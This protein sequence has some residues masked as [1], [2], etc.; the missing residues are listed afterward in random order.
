MTSFRLSARCVRPRD[1]LKVIQRVEARG[2]VDTA[3]R[4]RQVCSQIMRFGV[5]TGAVERDVT[6]D[7]KGALAVIPRKNHAAITEPATLGVLLRSIDGYEGHIAVVSALKLAPLLF[8]RPKGKGFRGALEYDSS[9]EQG[10]MIDT[11]MEGVGP[12]DLARS[13]ARSASSAVWV[14]QFPSTLITSTTSNVFVQNVGNGANVGLYWNV[15]SAAT[16]NGPTF[17]G[18]VLANDLI[19]SDGNLTINCGLLLS[20]TKQVT[21]NQ[22][23]VSITGCG[24]ASGGFDQGVNIG[25]GGTG[26]SGGGVVSFVPEPSTIALLGLGLLGLTASRR[27]SAR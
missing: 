9:K 22:D 5:A 13:S 14:F 25:S 8:V 11:N 2:A 27:K 10:R 17:A 21:L 18:N 24:N 16:L 7:L 12:R 15:H 26:G 23:K 3:H 19:S 6:P 1:I 4:I 20:A